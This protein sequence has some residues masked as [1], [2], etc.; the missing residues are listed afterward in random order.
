MRYE[1]LFPD[2]LRDAIRKNIPFVIPVG[3]LEYHSEHAV[4]GVDTLLIIKALEIIEKEMDI[5]I[6]PP[7]FYGAASYAVEPPENNGTLH[8]Q[9]HTLYLFAKDIFKSMLRVGIRN[10]HVFIH[11]QSEN[12]VSGM[13]TDLAFKLAARESIFEFLEKEKGEGWW[14]KEESKSYY[15]QHNAGT[16][17][18][19]WIKIHPFMEEK[20][21]KKFPIDHAGKQET[22]LMIS[23]CPEGID[24]KKYKKEKWYSEEAKQ[25]SKEYGEEIKKEILNYL[26]K[27]LKRENNV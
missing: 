3:V 12:F 15:S 5:V 22:S 7:F 21:Q 18:F 27:V 26:K 23:F 14:G 10:T 24:M 13:P 17:P 1:M 20:I 4:F 9:S 8:I 6:L 2:Q 16:G 11:H 19:N 25:A